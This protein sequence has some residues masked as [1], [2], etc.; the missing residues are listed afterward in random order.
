MYEKNLLTFM[1]SITGICF[2]VEHSKYNDVD[3]IEVPEEVKEDAIEEET[4]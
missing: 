1:M 4:L 3:S 2:Y